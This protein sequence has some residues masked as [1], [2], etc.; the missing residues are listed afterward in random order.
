M[1]GAIFLQIIGKSAKHPP[2]I[3]GT[4]SVDEDGLCWTLLRKSHGVEV[5]EGVV[6]LGQIGDIVDEFRRLSDFLKLNDAERIELFEELRKW[7][8]VDLRADHA[9]MS[10]GGQTVH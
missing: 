9:E 8:A 7:V 5:A 3:I 6:C 4:A 1:L 2:Q 10:H